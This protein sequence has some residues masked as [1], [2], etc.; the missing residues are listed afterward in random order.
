MAKLERFAS[1]LGC[2][3]DGKPH[4]QLMRKMWRC[5]YR[6]KQGV[7]MATFGFD[8]KDAWKSYLYN[9]RGDT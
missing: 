3:A 7:P 4:L 2:N 5:V 1:G 8:P 6:N 9:T